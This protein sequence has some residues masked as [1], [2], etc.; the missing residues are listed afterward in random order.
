MQTRIRVG[1]RY[2]KKINKSTMGTTLILGAGVNKEITLEF[3]LGSDLISQIRD[4]V[5]DETS[6]AGREC[7]SKNLESQI[8]EFDKD[9]RTSFHKHLNEFMTK[10]KNPSIDAFLDQI[11][12][13][14][15]FNDVKDLFIRLGR[16]LILSHILGWEGESKKNLDLE[17]DGKRR[18]WL[19][20][21]GDWIEENEALEIVTKHPL[22]IL[23]FNYDRVLEYYL[24]KRFDKVK[25]TY[26]MIHNVRHI[27]GTLGQLEGGVPF[28]ASSKVDF[29]FT[30]DNFIEIS[31][32]VNNIELISQRKDFIE[33]KSSVIRNRPTVRVIVMGYGFD[34]INNTGL[35]LYEIAKTWYK[36]T[37]SN[38]VAN[39]YPGAHFNETQDKVRDMVPNADIQENKSCSDFLNYALNKK[40]YNILHKMPS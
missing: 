23:T 12:I 38:F 26:W 11:D 10:M 6:P 3:G 20:V 27:Y 18:T 30:N 37:F 8:P 1:L 36:S 29:A 24:L 5:T 4:R 15:E 39:I 13:Y 7:L 17:L 19:S 33:V 16:C 14:P 31:K 28:G 2:Y 32:W 40:S 25:V 22:H 35:G 34:H 9:L 21:L